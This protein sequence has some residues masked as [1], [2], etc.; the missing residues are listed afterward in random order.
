MRLAG[1]VRVERLHEHLAHVGV[2][3][4][5]EQILGYVDKLLVKVAREGRARV[6]GENAHEHDGIV[7]VRRLRPVITV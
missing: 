5:P 3:A 1:F 2:A 7:L 4:G 6:V